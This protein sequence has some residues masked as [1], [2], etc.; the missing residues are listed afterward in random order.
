MTTPRIHTGREVLEKEAQAIRHVMDGLGPDFDRAVEAIDSCQ[1]RIVITGI[2]KSG[3]IAKKIASTFSSV[4]IP[5]IYLHP[6]DSIHGDL[7][8]VQKRDIIFIISN[9][10]ETDEVVKILPWIK[11]MGL[12]TIVATGVR[13]S[14]IGR[15]GDIVLEVKVEEACPFNLVPT[16]STTATLAL[17]DAIAVTLMKERNF[18]REDLALLHP[19]GSIGKSLLLHVE[20]LMH[21]GSEIPRVYDDAAMKDVIVEVSSKRLGVTGVFSKDDELVG[22]ITDG[23]LRRALEKYNNMLEKPAR[24]VMKGRPK[25]VKGNALAAH[26]LKMMEEFSITSLFVFEQDPNRPVGIVHIHDLLK[27]KIV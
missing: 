4:G 12:Q 25:G 7:G 3:L 10:G 2:G 18:S 22:I 8:V 27:A 9:S 17:G 6:A 24:D 21:T 14:T 16:C 26:A 15:Y 13:M 23:D 5:S 20:D 11:R 19:G 1:G